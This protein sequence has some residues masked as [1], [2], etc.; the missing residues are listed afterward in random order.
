MIVKGAILGA[1]TVGETNTGGL[2]DVE[3]VSL[4]VPAVI[5]LV[6]L[7]GSGLNFVGSVLLHETEHGRATWATIEPDKNWG[8]LSVILSLEEE[9]VDLLGGVS[10]IEE[11]REGTELIESGHLGEASD[12][13]H[14]GL[15][16]VLHNGVGT[17]GQKRS[18]EF[19]LFE[20]FITN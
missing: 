18:C 15:F 20:I 11:T 2:L 4:S 10:D 16:T 13:V 7:L 3:K 5:T 1:V 9:I 12:T 17:E 19:H 14:L 6:E 8:V